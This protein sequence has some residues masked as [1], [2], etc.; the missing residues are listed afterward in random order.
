MKKQMKKHSPFN[1]VMQTLGIFI[2][3]AFVTFGFLALVN[4]SYV[5]GEWNGFSR[6]IM[7]AIGVVFI[8]RIFDDI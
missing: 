2:I 8:I 7:G 3:I 6:F 1:G 5:F 4:W